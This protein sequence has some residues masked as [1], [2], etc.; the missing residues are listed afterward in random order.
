MIKRNNKGFTL[1]ELMISIFILTIVIFIGYR[2]INKSTIDIKNQSNINQG[3]LTVNDMN[4]YLTKDLERAKSVTIFSNYLDEKN[5]FT[6]DS[7][8]ENGISNDSLKEAFKEYS[9][10]KLFDYSYNIN[11]KKDKE[12]T[13]N[14]TYNV[15]IIKD[16]NNYKYSISRTENDKISIDFIKDE[17]LKEDEQSKELPFTIGLESPYEVT[18][19]Y[20]GKNNDEFVEHKFI[21]AS[22]LYDS[23]G[24]TGDGS[25]GT[26]DDETN[27]PP[28]EEL[29]EI[30]TEEELPEIPSD[31]N[32][33]LYQCIGYWTMDNK[34]YDNKYMKGDLYTWIKYGENTGESYG[35]QVKNKDKFYISAKNGVNS[36]NSNNGSTEAYI[37]DTKSSTQKLTD[38]IL[39]SV[40]ANQVYKIKI[41]VSPHTKVEQTKVAFNNNGNNSTEFIGITDETTKDKLQ[42]NNGLYTLEGGEEGKWYNVDVKIGSNHKMNFDINGMLNIDKSKVKSGYALIVYGDKAKEDGSSDETNSGNDEMKGDLILYFRKETDNNQTKWYRDYEIYGD[43]KKD[44]WSASQLDNISITIDRNNGTIGGHHSGGMSLTNYINEKIKKISGFKIKIVGGIQ[45]ESPK[46][47]DNTGTK[48]INFNNGIYE[49]INLPLPNTTQNIYI[50]IQKVIT[51]SNF[52]G[53]ASIVIDFYYKE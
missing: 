2:V 18:L 38:V 6:D 44:P 9:G 13:K 49:E 37:K 14:I 27:T 16:K 25:T 8:Q 41:Y 1:L 10:D 53:N 19:G 52:N 26:G 23:N 39:G 42:S 17:I 31:V 29:P 30:P 28:L 12:N 32:K 11:Y 5:R 22:R 40:P 48:Y 21:V 33:D 47:R 34:Y 24:G 45:L 4:E 7:T 43:Y 50:D 51:T 46:I 35:K 15:K 36:G 20:V 3:Q